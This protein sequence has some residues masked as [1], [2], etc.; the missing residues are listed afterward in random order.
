MATQSVTSLA[1][2]PVTSFAPSSVD[3]SGCWSGRSPWRSALS[4]SPSASEGWLTPLNLVYFVILGGMLV[5]R[6]AEFRY[7]MPMTA[8]GEPASIDHLRRYAIGVGMLGLAI[9][10]AANLLGNGVPHSS[11]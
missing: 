5:G 3:S 1:T 11:G 2:E 10:V 7:G 9:C 6:W 8:T 4:S